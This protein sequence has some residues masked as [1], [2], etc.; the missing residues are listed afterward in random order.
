VSDGPQRPMPQP[1]PETQRYWE[2]CKRH[3]LWLPYCRRCDQHFR[4]FDGGIKATT[5]T[6]SVPGPCSF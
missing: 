6:P 3:E 1:S 2:G 5:G 4:F